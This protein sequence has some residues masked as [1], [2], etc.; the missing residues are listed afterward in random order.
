MFKGSR[1]RTIGGIRSRRAEDLL[2]LVPFGWVDKICILQ[3]SLE[4]WAREAA[5]MASIY[6]NG[7]C[8][9]AAAAEN[10]SLNGC[11]SI[12]NPLDHAP[13]KTK[14]SGKAPETLYVHT[15]SSRVP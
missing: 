14:I 8:T 3:V 5:E 11:Y 1:P 9:I 12:R 6:E 15:Y 2:A 13:C 4:D 10:T 7:Y